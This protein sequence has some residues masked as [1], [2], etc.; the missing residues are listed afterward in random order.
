MRGY[1]E[2]WGSGLALILRRARVVASAT[3][4]WAGCAMSAAC[5]ST[6]T[7]PGT[8]ADVAA[9]DGSAG[10]VLADLQDASEVTPPLDAFD[11]EV[12]PADVAADASASDAGPSDSE[13]AD[14]PDLDVETLDATSGADVADTA[15]DA[16]A[17]DV[18]ANDAADS[19]DLVE[20]QE[21][22]KIDAEPTSPLPPAT[23]GFV[24]TMPGKFAV[25][26]L[27]TMTK[28][29][30]LGQGHA[31]VHGMGAEPGQNVVY[32]PNRDNGNIDR[33]EQVAG[34]PANWKI[35][36][37]WNAGIK[38]G[39]LDAS[40]D[41]RF[42]AMTA[43]DMVIQ[44]PNGSLPTFSKD[45]VVF[46]TKLGATVAKLKTVSPNPIAI[47]GDGS[48]AWVGNWLDHS[49]SKI[50]VGT[51]SEMAVYGLPTTN[52]NPKWIGPT[53]VTLSPDEKWLLSCDFSDKVAVLMPTDDPSQQTV[54]ATG[55]MAHW[56]EFSPDSSKVAITTWESFIVQGDEVASA[57]IPSATLVYDRASLKQL[58]KVTWKFQMAHN[59]WVPGSPWLLVSACYG[60]VLRYDANFQLTGQV[61]VTTSGEPM[62]AMTVSF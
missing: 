21:D 13:L 53:R 59:A 31:H 6:S 56:C 28:V 22:A 16:T 51:S 58:A 2:F 42:L 44:A 12:A 48:T 37:T 39:M 26:D 36:A 33:F 34:N 52:G 38:M 3:A 49:I 7:A 9:T 27:K 55:D 60:N 5:G 45:V 17:T 15:P 62:P 57:L 14:A 11:A 43:G 24:A 10:D 25:L 1:G 23:L 20:V 40:P 4:L 47:S 61:V 35:T 29:A 54:I 41:G 30:E 8:P 19:A 50:N 18:A 32:I 46:D